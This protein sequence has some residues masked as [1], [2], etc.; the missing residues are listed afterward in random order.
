MVR[1]RAL[2]PEILGDGSLAAAGRLLGLSDADMRT[3]LPA[4]IARG[5]PAPDQ[6]T[7]MIDLDGVVQWRKLRHPNL[8]GLI[9]HQPAARH[10]SD[11]VKNR[12]NGMF[13]GG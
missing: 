8:F 2:P 7:G 12:I 11:V 1:P 4:L 13:S 5:F 6:D 10:A 3:K 9:N